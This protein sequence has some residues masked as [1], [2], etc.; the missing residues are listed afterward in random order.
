MGAV[1]QLTCARLRHRPGRWVLLAVGVALALALPVLSAATGRLVAAQTLSHAI[2]QLPVGERT[3]IA[4]YGGTADPSVQRHDDQLVR[5]ALAALTGRPVGHRM[6]FGELA[7]GTGS[8]YRLG[9]TDDLAHQVR[10]TGGR[11]PASCTP[12]RCEV[13]LTGATTPPAL[14]PA[15]GIVVVGT[16]DRTDPLLLPGTFDPGPAARVLLGS[17]PDALQ[18]LASLEQFP[19]GSGW[20]APLDPERITSLGVPAYADKSRQVSDDLALR[21]RA[22]VLSVP[23]D[24]LLREDARA[25]ASQGRFALLGGATAVLVLGFVLVAAVGLRRE[26]LEVAGLLRR[27]GASTRDVLGLA[28]LGTGVAVVVGAV[29]GAAGGWL[30]A[31]LSAQAEPLHPP[32]VTLAT[33]SVLDALPTLVVLAVA[34]VALTAT[35][36]AWPASRSRTAWHVVELLAVGTIA[37]A[38]LVAARGAVGAASVGGDPLAVALPVLALTAAALV[39]ARLWV[40]LA[41]LVSRH[42]PT[43]A[44]AA[45]LAA[46]SGARRPLRTVV[47]VGFVTAA[48]GAVVFAGAYRATLQ[49]GSADTAAFDVP[50]DAR[51]SAGPQ[52]ADPV[53]LQAQEPLPGPA[54]AVVRTVAGVRTS[55]TSGD[56]VQVLG[57]DAGALRLVSR[58]DRTVGASSPDDV[59]SAIAAAQPAPGVPV[60]ASSTEL[61]LPVVSWT[62]STTGAVDVTAWVTAADGRERGVPLLQRDGL[63]RGALPD[64][65]PGATLTAI[66]LRENPADATRRQHRLGEGGTTSSFLSGRLVLAHPV[67][68]S[69]PWTSW[70]SRTAHVT[71][72]AES[73]TLDY[74][75]AGPLVVVRPGLVDRS[76]VLVMTD[77]V[78]ASRGTSLRLDLGAG[79]AVAAQVVG[80]LP[81]F[82]TTGP[83][84]LVADR[85][86]L[87]AALDDHEPGTGAPH[88]IW[89]GDGSARERLAA[90]IATAPW[91]QGRVETQE[92]NRAALESDAVGQGA[93]RL[94]LLAAA[95]ALLVAIVSL[96]L[97][98]VGERRDDAGQLL[99]HEADGVATATLRRSIW[100]RAVAAAVPALIAGTAAGLLL[101]RSVSTLV[102][103]SATGAAPT[104]PLIPSVGPGT[105]AVVLVAG[106]AVALAACAVA[107]SRMLRAAWPSGADQD[108]R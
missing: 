65:G 40:P 83:R 85:A 58:W 98:V 97:L 4:S 94:L 107:T 104:P 2:E 106:L 108:L 76:P 20:V 75:L 48:V 52:G 39:A 34:A 37:T 96:V 59:R 82:P 73:L 99:A 56:A 23:D 49:E 17:D 68:T 30:A 55:A 66:T 77:G 42:L 92:A 84:F 105:T 35:V 69:S 6:L 90:A 47:T 93:A 61:A 32:A 100:W 29:L 5:S 44:V 53:T 13:L 38:G 8:T 33:G 7:D 88:E 15:L 51:I 101:T 43:P 89:A 57:L 80:T 64:L 62:R 21:I 25:T 27:R 79:D 3:V 91:D 50:A 16:G 45:R 19:R 26:H 103:L 87:A 71:A 28:L 24:A 60:P 102:A 11:L 41:A 74:E 31:L 63:L 46:S 10:L 95:I 70:S 9:A 54:Y 72:T 1:G 86:S 36:L 81:R 67:D 78:T 22:L 14:D 12:T 18:R